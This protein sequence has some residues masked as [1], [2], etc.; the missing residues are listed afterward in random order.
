[1]AVSAIDKYQHA[2]DVLD[3]FK[4]TKY[5][6]MVSFTGLY[7]NKD[8]QHFKDMAE[9]E[10]DTFDYVEQGYVQT[11]NYNNNGYFDM[12]VAGL[13]FAVTLVKGSP[14]TNSPYGK[15]RV[16]VPVERVFNQDSGTFYFLNSYSIYENLYV[17]VVYVD[18]LENQSPETQ[19]MLADLVTLETHNKIIRFDADREEW[20]YRQGVWLEVFVVGD[21]NI[22][23]LPKNSCK[24]I[25]GQVTGKNTVTSK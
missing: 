7:R 24:A 5:G 3:G 6:K 19:T 23:G 1:M 22:G 13:Y 17:V 14:P 2:L 4:W 9:Q 12:Y 25:D 8:N 21:L 20:V 16:I 10:E 18:V 11:V 15:Y